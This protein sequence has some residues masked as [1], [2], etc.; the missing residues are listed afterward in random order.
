MGQHG[1]ACTTLQRLATYYYKV[2]EW[3]RLGHSVYSVYDRRRQACCTQTPPLTDHGEPSWPSA[4]FHV[5]SEPQSA[6]MI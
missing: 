5:D 4:L 6:E 3:K 2:N 1:S